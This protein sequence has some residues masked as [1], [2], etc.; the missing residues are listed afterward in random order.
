LKANLLS[1]SAIR[2]SLF[3]ILFIV[4]PQFIFNELSAQ[5]YLRYFEN[6]KVGF[7]DTTGKVVIKARFAQTG[8]FSE[9]LAP[10]RLK[11]LYGYIDTTG[12][13]VIPPKYD[14]AMEFHDGLA[15]VYTDS[16]PNY[17]NKYGDIPF[18][19]YYKNIF[20]FCNGRA[21]VRLQNND[22]GI[23]NTKCELI[24]QGHYIDL[25]RSDGYYLVNNNRNNTDPRNI[26]LTDSL[27]NVVLD[28]GVFDYIGNFREGLIYV[29]YGFDSAYGQIIRWAFLNKYFESVIPG[30]EKYIPV[31]NFS[32]GLAR[33]QILKNNINRS[34]DT[35]NRLDY[36]CGYIDTLGNLL[37]ADTN[38]YNGGDFTDGTAFVYG[39]NETAEIN[40]KGE[41]IRR[42]KANQ[43]I[44]S[45]TNGYRM[46]LG[47]DD[48]FVVKDSN[49]N[50]AT[51]RKF[52]YIEKN[53]LIKDGLIMFYDNGNNIL[54]GMCNYK[55]DV[56]LE[57]K[58]K[59][60]DS[61]R[62]FQNGILRII[63]ENN[64][65]YLNKRGEIFWAERTSDKPDTL[66][67]DFKFVEN[68]NLKLGD[69][70]N[71]T[72]LD[73]DFSQNKISL[74]RKSGNS[75]L[76]KNKYATQKVYLINAT[77]KSE[78]IMSEEHEIYITLQ[79][80][81]SNKEWVDIEDYSHSWCGNSYSQVYLPDGYYWEFDLPIYKGEQKTK[82]RYKLNTWFENKH[83]K[84][85]T[86]Y[87]NEFEGSINPSQFWRKHNNGYSFP[88]ENRDYFLNGT[89]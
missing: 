13:Y 70:K 47:S 42:Y 79:A 65:G 12:E 22:Y 88:E 55:G 18:A 29:K 39:G 51:D 76:Y 53:S 33:V 89:L 6:G 46:V 60:Y 26:Y 58:I 16:I 61:E 62:W 4:T 48:Y 36:Y 41:I 15:V 77:K 11:G 34:E 27:G 2:N 69:Y 31:S 71:N 32:E 86:I 59:Q 63:T 78:E 24:L 67:M 64:R 83:N 21:L 49:D 72:H 54:Y 9:G 52:R 20:T 57:P 3:L 74:V 85:I 17:I 44:E 56:L 10:A 43:I 37:I 8:D 28:S 80:L 38:Y 23:I 30:S 75:K 35:H 81:N 19:N 14:Y 84:G 5:P 45:N 68:G 73:F 25:P 7:I 82:F 1:N 40:K 66:D 87:S 50:L